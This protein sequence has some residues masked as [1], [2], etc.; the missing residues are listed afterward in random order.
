M[1][2]SKFGDAI[3]SQLAVKMKEWKSDEVL[4]KLYQCPLKKALINLK[5]I[6]YGA[7]AEVVESE[8]GLRQALL[9]RKNMA[10]IKLPFKEK[11]SK[12]IVEDWGGIT[13]G[14]ASLKNCIAKADAGDF[15]FNRI[16][17]WSKNSAFGKPKD[18]AIYDARVIY[19]LNWLLFKAGSNYYFPTPSGRNSVMELLNYQILLFIGH[20]KVEGIREKLK[21]DI[22]SRETSPGNKSSF[23]N[24]LKRDLF[25]KEKEAFKEY[26]SLLKSV[27]RKL[28]PNDQEGVTK[29]E[30]MLFSLADK[31]IALEVL[32][33]FQ[34]SSKTN[35]LAA[36]EN[37]ST[38]F[39][40]R[41]PQSNLSIGR[42]KGL[43]DIRKT[44]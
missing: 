10:D 11:L 3:V 14:K 32:G 7:I 26:C 43:L 21:T 13:T 24:K 28:Y 36:D 8:K 16:A 5:N 39:Q 15:D 1:S 44:R 2:D 38:L 22:E 9:L 41:A 17:S 42:I 31:N 20:Y 27:T 19:S 29:V 4:G 6:G 25:I 33:A 37:C 23:S 35:A 12:W 34:A 30:M 18:Y 40:L